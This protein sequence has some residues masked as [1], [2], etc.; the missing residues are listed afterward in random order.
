MEGPTPPSKDPWGKHS[1]WVSATKINR[2]DFSL[3]WN[4][5]LETGGILVVTTLSSPRMPNS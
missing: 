3:T 1:D 5:D 4:A 2:K